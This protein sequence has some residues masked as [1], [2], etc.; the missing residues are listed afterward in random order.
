VSGASHRSKRSSRK[1]EAGNMAMNPADWIKDSRQYLV[2]VQAEYKKI[3][4]PP[5]Q[6]ALAGTIGVVAVVVVVT[7]VLGV[8]DFVLSRIMQFVLQ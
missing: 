5:Q 7:T 3:T 4:W 2:E 1:V 6:E 8:V